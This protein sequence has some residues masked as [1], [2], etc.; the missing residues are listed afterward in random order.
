MKRGLRSVIFGMHNPIF[1]GFF[2]TIAWI[3]IYH[4]I[5]SIREMICI[6]FHDIGYIK[7]DIIDGTEDKHPE[8]GAKICGQIFGK[9]YY[10]LCISHSRDYATKNNLSLSKLGYADKYSVFVTPNLFYLIVGHL[11]GEAN[12]EYEDTKNMRWGIKRID[13]IRKNY[14]TWWNNN[15]KDI[16]NI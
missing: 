4:E 3:K 14:K 6:L 1:H 11:G 2:V 16:R 8:M 5:P 9:E 13:I 15:Y 7:Q 12:I 10:N